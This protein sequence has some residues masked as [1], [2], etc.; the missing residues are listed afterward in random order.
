MNRSTDPTRRTTDAEH[1]PVIAARAGAFFAGAMVA[2]VLGISTS[3]SAQLRPEQVLVVYDSRVFSSTDTTSPT[4]FVSRDVAEYYAGSAKVPGG[5]GNQPGVRPGVRTVNLASINAPQST[6]PDLSVTQWVNNIRNPLRTWLSTN[7]PNG[8]I[9][10]IVLTKGI[11]SRI[12]QTSPM[13][14]GD[15]PNSAANS[16]TAGTYTTSSIDSELALLWQ[17]LGGETNTAGGTFATGIIA[18]PYWRSTLPISAWPTLN[19]RTAKNFT[20]LFTS[21]A[22]SVGM[23]WTAS[24]I[25]TNNPPLTTELTPGDMYLVSR[26]DGATVGDVRGMIDRAQNLVV[27][28]DT[29]SFIFDE[30]NADPL[31]NATANSEFDNFGYSPLFGGDDYEQTRDAILADGRYVASRVRSDFL[32]GVN[33]FLVGPRVNYNGQGGLV[34]TPVLLVS[35]YGSN[36]PGTLPGDGTTPTPPEVRSTYA[37]SFN[38]APGAIFNSTES[39]N[40]RDFGG[41]GQPPAFVQMQASAFIAAGGTFAA[42][43]AWEPFTIS[44]PDDLQ[45][46]RNFILGNLSWG[47]A[48]FTALPAL[49]F[50]QIIIGDPLARMVRTCDDLTGDARISV[51]DLYAWFAASASRKDL[52]RSGTVTD[53]DRRFVEDAVRSAR[54]T[55][56]VGSQR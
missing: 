41:L 7:D 55:D 12:F 4:G 23:F 50:Q 1:R 9:R 33:N 53:T 22:S 18:N 13:Y 3:A 49:S 5:A 31:T 44:I 20:R 45:I 15:L 8:E 40:G 56:M 6:F 39:F 19:R 2:G 29:A 11:P 25:N 30:A 10:C 42:V 24:Q 32:S 46:A 14:A 48:A 27:D 37:A 54:D 16:F 26:L 21:P 51:E 17:D 36:A 52:N 38:L 43:N 35:G 28:V 47:E 34:T